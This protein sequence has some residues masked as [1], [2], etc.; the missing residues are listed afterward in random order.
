[1]IAG[2][3]PVY[4]SDDSAGFEAHDSCSCSAEPVYREGS[5]WPAGSEQYASLWQEAREEPGDTTANFRRL[6]ATP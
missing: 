5:A 6:L 3:G 1:M 2:R 4:K